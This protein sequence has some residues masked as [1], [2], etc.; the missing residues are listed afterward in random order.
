MKIVVTGG[1]GYI[2]THVCLELLAAQHEVIVIPKSTRTDRIRS[3]ADVAAFT[4]SDADMA[5]LDG[6]GIR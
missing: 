2:G 3:N 4:L 6:L 1:A 5:A